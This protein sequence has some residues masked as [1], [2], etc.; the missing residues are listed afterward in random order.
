MRDDLGNLGVVTEKRGEC[1]FCSDDSQV[2]IGADTFV[3]V[4]AVVCLVDVLP[5][6]PQVAACTL[7][8]AE[9]NDLVEPCG[10]CAVVH[11]PQIL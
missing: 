3:A 5:T 9:S 8:F 7:R 11:E 10:V 6:D 2:E 4:P 1:G